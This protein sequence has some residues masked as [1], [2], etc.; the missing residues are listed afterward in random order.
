T[1]AT[2]SNTGNSFGENSRR[3][4]GWTQALDFPV[5]DIRQEAAEH[6]WFVGDYASFDPRNQQV[7]QTVAKLL[8]LADVDYGI[9]YDSERTAGNDVRRV[10]EEGL[11]ESLV[12]H[13]TG[14][15]AD[16]S[17][18]S[19]ITTDPHSYNTI[20]NEYPDFAPVKEIR[21]YSQVLAQLLR[22]GRLK[23][24][25]PL[26]LRVTLHD[27]CH[28]GR[29]N[30]QTAPPRDVLAMIGCELV[31]MPRHGDNSF[32]CGAG[33]GRI[34]IPDKP[35]VEK[36][37]ENRMHEAAA[38]NV[39][40]F[41]VYCPKDLTMFEDARKTSG[42]EGDLV[43]ADLAE[44]VAQAI[45]LDKLNVKDA[46]RLVDQIVE[47]AAEQI[48]ERAVERFAA[49][50][51]ERMPSIAAG[52]AAAT[53]ATMAGHMAGV[54]PAAVSTPPAAAMAPPATAKPPA[55]A[56]A[57]A[58]DPVETTDP[59]VAASAESPVATETPAAQTAE[60]TAVPAESTPSASTGATS[61][62]TALTPIDDIPW[63][64]EPLTAIDLPSYEV[65][66]KDGP[67]IMVAVKHVA[68]L[69]DEFAFREDSRDVQSDYFDFVLNEWDD[70]ALEH[71]LRLVEA[72]GSGEVVAVTIG[73]DGAEESLRRILAKGAHR[74]VRV[75]ADGLDTA[76][77]VT[78]ARILAG[79]VQHEQPD[80]ILTGAQSGEHAH[81]ATGTALA[82]IL[83]LPHLAIAV[84]IEWSG[85]GP[86]KVTR[87]LEGGLRHTVT[88]P[89]PAL[90][91]IQTGITP[92]YATLRMI[93][94]ARQKP[95]EVVDGSAAVGATGGFEVRR[96]YTPPKG[97]GAEMISG[98]A[99]DVAAKLAEVIRN[100]KGA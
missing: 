4:G 71:A 44:L 48:A 90:V 91:S 12:E 53:A 82:R 57:V 14:Q 29:F 62:A 28:L 43:V 65:P 45:Q 76:D 99:E 84:E 70:A 24:T 96:M 74:G 72:A 8:R 97:K 32:C 73:A 95:L 49:K 58:A 5:K 9:L 63:K 50:L 69:G 2:I 15:M 26:G 46:P 55:A 23:V 60:Q 100:F 19:I 20:R 3:R 13:N 68:Q 89:T 54:A 64:A 34:W 52:A 11:F 36:P 31:E 35:G 61:A 93:K 37:S 47:A 77:P 98:S 40:T 22:D 56:A 87:E 80:L 92:R 10:G 42:H 85:S 41:V 79:V 18:G 59:A 66:A 33:G 16:A 1:L 67:R 7:S 94:Q 51:E 30:G 39:D 6:L 25:K 38:L 83:G 78:I 27:P 21:H 75:W 81:G 88:M 17:F 86:A